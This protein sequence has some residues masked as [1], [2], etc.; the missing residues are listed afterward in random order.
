MIK[1]MLG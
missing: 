1:V